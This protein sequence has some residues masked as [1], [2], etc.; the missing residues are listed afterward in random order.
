L[1]EAKD[2]GLIPV[3]GKSVVGGK[4]MKAEDILKREDILKDV[5]DQF[6][7]DL[8]WYGVGG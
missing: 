8:Y 5:P 6:E 1:E 2:L 3:P 7:E 4:V